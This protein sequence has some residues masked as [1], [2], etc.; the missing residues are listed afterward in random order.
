M[1]TVITAALVAVSYAATFLFGFGAGWILS[2]H[3]E[4]TAKQKLRT[5][6]SITVTIV[7]VVTTIMDIA[8][9]GYTI[10]PLIHVIM[11]AI[12]GYFFTDEEIS[13]NIGSN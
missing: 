12:V 2:A 9:T 11:G 4:M 13:F 5:A 3:T 10:S 8:L 1:V 7:W 6:I